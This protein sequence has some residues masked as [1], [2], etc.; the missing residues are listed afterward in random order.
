M[1]NF[2]HGRWRLIEGN[3][4]KPRLSLNL[5]IKCAHTKEQSLH[6]L[7]LLKGSWMHMHSNMWR[8][9]LCNCWRCMEWSA[10][11]GCFHT[12]VFSSIF[13]YLVL[14]FTLEA[15]SLYFN[16]CRASSFVLFFKVMWLRYFDLFIPLNVFFWFYKAFSSVIVYVDT[17]ILYYCKSHWA[18][19]YDK[20][21]VG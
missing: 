15:S 2:T 21:K 7:E 12:V 11:R 4:A 19:S 9:N 16:Y 17:V 1:Q 5:Y 18:K 20:G 13:F 10:T 3:R 14:F 8:P 6:V